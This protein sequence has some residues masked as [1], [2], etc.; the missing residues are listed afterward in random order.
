MLIHRCV[1]DRVMDR[2]VLYRMTVRELYAQ[3]ASLQQTADVDTA[4]GP[5]I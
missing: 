1:R 2:C 3:A 5:T 4:T